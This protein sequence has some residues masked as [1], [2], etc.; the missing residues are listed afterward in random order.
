MSSTLAPLLSALTSYLSSHPATRQ[1]P[2]PIPPPTLTADIT[3]IWDKVTSEAS[4]Q[5]DL[6]ASFKNI[7]FLRVLMELAG[8]EVVVAA[9]NSGELSEPSEDADDETK[10][11]F[12]VQLHDRLDV[13]LTL[14]EVVYHANQD[15]TQLEPGALFIP[16]L[17]ELVEL[18]SVDSWRGLWAYIESRAKRYTIDM[19]ASKG[20]ALPLLRTI[21]SFLRTLPRAPS[22]LVFRGRIHQFASAV[23][24]VADKSAINLRGDYA[25][26]KTI[27]EESAGEPSGEVKEE[28]VKDEDGKEEN[29]KDEGEGGEAKEDVKDEGGD[30]V[31]EDA[32]SPKQD[33]PDFYS[34]LWSLQQYFAHPPS[35]DGP[36]TGSPPRTPF[37]VFQDKSNLVL[38]VL[39]EQTKK[40]KE[41]LSEDGEGAGKKRKRDDAGAAEFFHPRYLTGKRLLDY[42]LA[43]PSFRR[44]IL[45]QYI[46]LFQFLLH[47]T[48]GFVTKQAFT[49]GMPR[50]FVLGREEEAWVKLK[51]QEI[52]EELKAMPDGADFESTVISI[53]TRERH[54]ANWKNDGCPESAFECPPLEPETAED[55]ARAWKRRLAPPFGFAHKVGSRPLSALWNNGYRGLDQLK[56][57]N[58]ETT[59]ETLESEIAT[60]QEDE[61]DDAAMGQV[62]AAKVAANKERKTSITWRGLRLTAQTDLRHFSSLA[63]KRDLRTLTEAVKKAREPPV[64]VKGEK[65][66]AGGQDTDDEDVQGLKRKEV[67]GEE[68]DGDDKVKKE[69]EKIAEKEKEEGKEGERGGEDEQGDKEMVDAENSK[70]GKTGGDGIKNEKEEGDSAADHKD[71]APAISGEVE[72]A[73]A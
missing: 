70:D 6:R 44:Q 68:V 25:E 49:G 24:G 59:V 63:S 50:S 22:D 17:E 35:L 21:N 71:A 39:Y 9:I 3:A 8:R 13:V 29:V 16:L 5:D 36:A 54:Y 23:F 34:T 32:S 48:P 43:D 62:D 15:V 46:I 53:I 73:E 2:T 19:P 58:T 30:A 38:P 65:T 27:W 10:R 42:E 56:G 7:E 67:T 51:A 37:Q 40:E 57:K 20:K 26:V 52:K 18:L 41:A 64:V 61:D 45:V 4:S 12:Q 31:M 47:L 14:Y 1:P 69:L 55:A 33:K 60:M 11:V 72:M 28:G 66:E